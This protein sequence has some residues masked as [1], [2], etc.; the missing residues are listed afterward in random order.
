MQV[1]RSIIKKRLEEQL[2]SFNC[3]RPSHNAGVNLGFTPIE[4]A[5]PKNIFPRGAIHEFM[6]PAEMDLPPTSGFITALLSRIN[7]G[8]SPVLW[9]GDTQI[10]PPALT[11]FGISPNQVIFIN[12]NNQKNALWAIEQALKCDRLAAVVGEIRDIGLTES[13]RLQLAVENTSVTGFIIRRQARLHQTTACTSRWRIA[14]IPCMQKDGLP[15]LGFPSWQV[16]LL[17]VRNGRPGSWQ[18]Q[19]TPTGF[20]AATQK[21]ISIAEEQLRNTG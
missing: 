10:F 2:E 3:L 8:S 15:G 21:I 7:P 9:I 16:E 19:W 11:A 1:E 5:F 20:R 13:R 18:L 14:S 17:K 12:T 4:K 6:C